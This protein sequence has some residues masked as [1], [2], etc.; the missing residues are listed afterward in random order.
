MSCFDLIIDLLLAELTWKLH[1]VYVQF[2]LVKAY[3]SC[4][5]NLGLIVPLLF[6]SE[7]IVLL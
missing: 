4:I 5:W 3:S 2:W 1:V 7:V 6:F